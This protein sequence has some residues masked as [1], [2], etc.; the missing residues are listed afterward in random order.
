M[1]EYFCPKCNSSFTGF[2]SDEEGTTCDLGCSKCKIFIKKLKNVPNE[3]GLFDDG[4]GYTT[5]PIIV[6]DLIINC[7]KVYKLKVFL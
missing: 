5:L 1:I 6:C 7:I 3:Y 4:N 2:I